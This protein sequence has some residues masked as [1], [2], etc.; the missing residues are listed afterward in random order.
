MK[1]RKILFSPML[2][3]ILF[4][5][6][7]GAMAVATF[8]E[9]DFGSPAAYKSVYG[10]RWFEFILL[11]LAVNLAGQIFEFKLYRREK[12]TVFIFHAAFIIILIGSA[13]TRYFGYDGTFHV[14]EGETENRCYSG[15]NIITVTASDMSGKFLGEVHSRYED[16]G[17]KD[18]A[19]SETLEAGGQNI[20]VV[21]A[22]VIS[23]AM[24]TVAETKSGVPMISFF[25]STRMGGMKNYILKQGDSL[26]AEGVKIAFGKSVNADLTVFS[27]SSGFWFESAHSLSQIEMMKGDSILFKPGEKVTARQMQ[28][29]GVKGIRIIPQVMT[30]TGAVRAVSAGN[31]HKSGKTALVFHFMTGSSPA[32]VTLWADEADFSAQTSREINGMNIEI[33]YGAKV[34]TLPFSIRLEDFRMD[35]YPGSNSP[36]GYNSDVTVIDTEAGKEIPYSIYMNNVLKYK[37]YRFFQSSFDKDRMGTVLSVNHD[38]AGMIITYFGYALMIIFIVLSIINRKA[39]FHTVTASQWSSPFK[40]GAA[41][42]ALLTVMSFTVDMSGQ[43]LIADKKAADE[44]GKILVQDQKGR[45]KP[46]YT[47]SS[48][49]MRKVAREKSHNGLTPMQVYLGVYLDFESW[50]HE[51]LIKISNPDLA[52]R[53]GVKG[54]MAAFSDLVDFTGGT[55]YKL[56]ED[57]QAAYEKSPAERNKTDKEIMKVDERVNILYM[58]YT[59]EFARFFPLK[60][61][62]HNWATYTDAVKGAVSRE[63]SLYLRNV[64]PLFAEALKT[65]NQPNALQIAESVREYQERFSEYELMSE[66]KTSAEV[67]YYKSNIFERLFPFYFMVGLLML[68]TLIS[69]V[70]IGRK[71]NNLLVKIL[72][73]IIY[74]G[75]AFHTFG[76]ALRWFISGHA[77]M[78]NGYESM[79]FISWVLLLA[80]II[81]GNRSK[82]ALS[83]TAV[84][85]A[86]TLLVAHLSFMDPEITNLVPVLQSYWLTLHVSVITGSYGFLGL[87][88]IL[89]LINL[90]LIALS[91]QRNESRVGATLGEL[92][93]INYKALVLGIYFL[94]IGTFLGAVW[95]NESWGRYWGWDPKETWSLITIVIYSIVVH[96]R[97]IPALKDLYTFNLLSLFSFS[98]VLMTFFGVNYYLSGLHSYASGDPVPVPSFVYIAVITLIAVSFAAYVKYSKA[99][100][101]K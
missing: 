53:L 35:T 98:S 71:D 39:L 77:P 100:R 27:D 49:I 10:T 47:L 56:A 74:A 18:N 94:T 90:I 51:P 64:I 42:I 61:S 1:I 31:D 38:P 67:F 7:A 14:R 73:Y 79:L 33:K 15:S 92:T 44:F 13:V 32:T 48:D 60:D 76:L 97:L 19:W 91:N 89:G 5:V 52:R 34:T 75:F 84:L 63:D 66:S 65:N 82:F 50:Q 25:T 26:V 68:I 23:N 96:S 99:G 95:A 17:S 22:Q 88:A 70:V 62:T 55:T 46:L 36:S 72:S 85:G 101:G 29:I 28:I 45:T 37:G 2:M 9:N 87:G 81:F 58:I 21:L 43:K 80:G 57:V 78:S 24:E 6:F 4:V 69:N 16:S 86:M 54:N 8:I 40:K 11:L 93:V 83:A 3:G 41:V 20:K 59:G 12:L 30:P